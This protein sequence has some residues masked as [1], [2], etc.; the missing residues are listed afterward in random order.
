MLICARSTHSHAQYV[1]ENLGS[2]VP[3]PQP[4]DEESEGELT[5]SDS[6]VDEDVEAAPQRTHSKLLYCHSCDSYPVV[7][8]GY[9]CAVRLA[10][11]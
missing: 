1:T 10:H 8:S 5:A 2:S 7:T 6:D 4:I 9:L 11:S 3:E